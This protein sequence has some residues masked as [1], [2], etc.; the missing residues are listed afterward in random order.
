MN[1]R[2]NS[3][4]IRFD[5]EMFSNNAINIIP[6]SSL[7]QNIGMDGSGTHSHKSQETSFYVELGGRTEWQ[8]EVVEMEEKVRKE[9][10]KPFHM[11]CFTRTKRFLGN[12]LYKKKK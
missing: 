1:V 3:W 11:S 7:I 8:L 6:R 5:Y 10:C 2:I 9:F 4:A 12:L